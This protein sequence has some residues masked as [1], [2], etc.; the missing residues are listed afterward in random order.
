MEAVETQ[1]RCSTMEKNGGEEYRMM[2]DNFMRTTIEMW[3]DYK[4]A[5]EMQDNGDDRQ[6][7]LADGHGSRDAGQQ[8][9]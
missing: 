5:V 2:E 9:H 7:Q 6:G 4:E 3:E 1:Q 8:G